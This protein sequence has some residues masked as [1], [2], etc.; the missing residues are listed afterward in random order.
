MDISKHRNFLLS[1]IKVNNPSLFP[2][3]NI[4]EDDEF[5][6]QP[7]IETARFD[8]IEGF[9]LSPNE[10]QDIIDTSKY[11]RKYKNQM[12]MKDKVKAD[13]IIKL[14]RKKVTPEIW[15]DWVEYNEGDDRIS[16][17]LNLFNEMYYE[18]I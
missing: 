8:K 4:H 9:R 5:D 18:L 14:F 16:H 13:E 2:W 17:I 10:I 3:D 11:E 7:Q 6:A 1:E 15:K 12:E